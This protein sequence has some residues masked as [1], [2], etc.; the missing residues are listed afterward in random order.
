MRTR[1]WAD[2][3]GAVVAERYSLRVLVYS[4]RYQ[5]EFLA[6]PAVSEQDGPALSV[7]LLE[8]VPEEIDKEL[9]RIAAAKQLRHR[10]LLV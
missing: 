6:Y 9:A 10:N 7:T 2:L 3:V 4:G 1:T 8:C 5:A